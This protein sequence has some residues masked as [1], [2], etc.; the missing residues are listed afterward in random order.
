MTTENNREQENEGNKFN[1][2]YQKLEYVQTFI[3]APKE[4]ENDFSKAKYKYRNVEDIIESAKPLLHKVSAT[5][6]LHDELFCLGERIYVKATAKFTDTK[7]QKSIEVTANAR[8]QLSR[9]GFDEAQITGGASSYARKYALCGLLL[10]DNSTADI[11]SLDNTEQGK[12][13]TKKKEKTLT[14]RGTLIMLLEQKGIALKD[15]A[16]EKG[17]KKGA[18][19][20]EF[21]RLIA[22]LKGGK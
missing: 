11:D 6:T 8:E 13:T 20:E 7:S 16:K 15:F 2:V 19:D 21:N 22:E 1:N 10:V 5:I 18:T 12:T 4:K 14:P 3:K 9:T 17:L